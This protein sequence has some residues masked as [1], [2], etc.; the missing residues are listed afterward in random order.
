MNLEQQSFRDNRSEVLI[1]LFAIAR[2]IKAF[3]GKTTEEV[4]Q[5]EASI[6]DLINNLTPEDFIELIN[7]I[8]GVLRKKPKEEWDMDGK[9]VILSGFIGDNTPPHFKDKLDLLHKVLDAAKAINTESRSL[10]DIGI[11]FGVGISE[12]HP[13]NDANGRTGRLVYTLFNYGIDKDKIREVLDDHGRDSVDFDIE[14][15]EYI[16]EESIRSRVL[17]DEERNLTGLFKESI[18]GLKFDPSVSEA[19]ILKFRAFLKQSRGSEPHLWAIYEFVQENKKDNVFWTSPSGERVLL[20]LDRLVPKLN[21]EDLQ[22]ILDRFWGFKKE[23]AELL[24]DSIVNPNKPEYI[25]KGKYSALD[26]SI[27]EQI[28]NFIIVN[29]AEP[30]VGQK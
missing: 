29:H 18:S 11:L 7:G 26:C 2:N 15:I 5:N 27:L 13:F 21:E 24:V 8:N 17:K 28:K 19:M 14:H 10:E 12:I 20:D 9:D 30:R 16:V 3:H 4:F 6:R 22:N 23:I 25:G 1:R